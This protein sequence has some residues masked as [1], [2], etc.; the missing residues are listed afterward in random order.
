MISMSR[1]CFCHDL[2]DLIV[3]IWEGFYDQL[4]VFGVPELS[5]ECIHQDFWRLSRETGG[6]VQKAESVGAKGR[7]GRR[8]FFQYMVR[9][10]SYNPDGDTDATLQKDV[11]HIGRH[12]RNYV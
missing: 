10:E 4:D 11:S 5:A 12:D 8:T 3:R 1:R 6:D 9:T 2:L 7:N